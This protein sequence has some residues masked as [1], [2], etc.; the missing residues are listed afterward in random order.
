MQHSQ[1]FQSSASATAPVSRLLNKADVLKIL[2]ITRN[3]LTRWI[4]NAEARGVPSPFF[5]MVPGGHEVATV[6]TLRE[7]VSSVRAANRTAA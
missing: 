4:R 7:W 3:T 1:P 5:E 6:A 2:G